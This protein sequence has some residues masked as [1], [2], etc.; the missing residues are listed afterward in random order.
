MTTVER[1]DQLK[2]RSGSEEADWFEEWFGVDYLRI[3]QLL[4]EK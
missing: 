1:R 3:Y 2:Q 4:D